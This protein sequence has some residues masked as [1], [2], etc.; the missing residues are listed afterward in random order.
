MKLI[1]EELRPNQNIKNLYIVDNYEIKHFENVRYVHNM[2]FDYNDGRN[3]SW[4]VN[5]EHLHSSLETA[6]ND[7]YFILKVKSNDVER[8][9]RILHTKEMIK[10]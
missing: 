10:H 7:L 5:T 3:Q 4:F 1:F 2:T 6:L 8:Q 9:L